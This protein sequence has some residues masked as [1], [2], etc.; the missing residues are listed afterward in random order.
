MNLC[1]IC[2]PIYVVNEKF[3]GCVKKAIVSLHEV[4]HSEQHPE[5]HAFIHG[6]VT[7]EEWMKEIQGYSSDK[8]HIQINDVK[9]YGKPYV[10]NQIVKNNPSKY[11]LSFD[12]DMEVPQ[13]YREN[14]VARMIETFENARNNGIN[15]GFLASDLL[16]FNIHLPSAYVNEKKVKTKFKEETISFGDTRNNYNDVAGSSVL[17]LTKEFNGVGG[18]RQYNLFDGDG[19]LRTDIRRKY[20]TINAILKSLPVYHN[21]PEDKEYHQWKVHNARNPTLDVNKQHSPDDLLKLK[22]YGDK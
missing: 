1:N 11:I 8:V 17:M 9:N 18:Y 10:I 21:H 2:C 14:F 20:N 6:Y 19:Y 15:V 5:V 12:H 4:V 3:L 7:K 16:T 22:G 13:L